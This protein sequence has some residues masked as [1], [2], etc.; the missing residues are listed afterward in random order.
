MN[1]NTPP[2]FTT[3]LLPV[4]LVISWQISC[5]QTIYDPSGF[6]DYAFIRYDTNQ[7][8]L[9]RNNPQYNILF[10]KFDSLIKTGNNQIKIVHIGGSHIQA[11]IYTH[12]M[13]QEL[14]SF[15]P[16]ILGSRGFFF[17]YTLAQTNSPSN[18]WIRFSGTWQ[19]S[20]NTQSKPVFNLGLSGITSA[21]TSP[22]G[23][24]KIVASYDTLQHYD[25][26]HIKIFCNVTLTGTIPSVN[27]GQLVNEV[28]INEDGGYIQYDLNHYT[29]TLD[30]HIQQADS[31]IEPFQL[32]GIS[33]ESDDP[34]VIYSS[35]GVN[36]AKLQS[37]IRCNLFI[38]HLKAL[39]PDWIILSIGTN[40]G[41]TRQFDSEAFRSEYKLLLN[42]IHQ[43]APDAAI[44]LTV[45]NDSY[46]YK[47]YVNHNTFRIRE[48][49]FDL[50]RSEN[51]G[52]WDFYTIM[53]GLN[54]SSAWYNNG[55]MKIDHIHFNKTGY[56]LEGNLFFNAFLK[57]WEY[58]LI[59]QPAAHRIQLIEQKSN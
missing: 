17:P 5:A 12:R 56:I 43:A 20:R 30:I 3:L 51:Y 38:Q 13:R 21:L 41:N 39:H 15:Y 2:I 25:F 48:I 53:G 7:F 19:T 35:I 16:G 1:N 36:G 22:S 33:L 50:A 32:Y 58:H 49:I 8:E 29:D 52:V 45:P 27:P 44:L 37:Y 34:G 42:T 10:A 57:S 26:N 4:Y 23:S 6:P 28:I 24:L 18:L 40:D 11:D 31:I 55:L 46:L 54:S 47:R 9:V 59:S 14:Q